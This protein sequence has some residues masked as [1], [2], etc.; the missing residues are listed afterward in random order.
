[1]PWGMPHLKSAISEKKQLNWK[2]ALLSFTTKL[3][4]FSGKSQFSFYKNTH[5]VASVLNLP[6]F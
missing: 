4:Q 5:N 6:F 3:N 1:M 2:P